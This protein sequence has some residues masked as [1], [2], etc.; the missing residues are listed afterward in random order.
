MEFKDF[1]GNWIVK[2]ILLAFALV[3]V[4]LLGVQIFLGIYTRHGD[5]I[6]VPDFVSLSLTE[7]EKAAERVGMRTEVVDSLY[8]RKMPRGAIVRQ[9]PAAGTM[10]KSGRRI[11]LTINAVA[12]KQIPM[13]NLVGYSLRSASAELAARGLTLGRQIYVR[14]IATNNVLKQIYNN[15]EIV[16][17]TMIPNDA[18]I[19][20]VLGLNPDDK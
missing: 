1:I 10:V 2:N 5:E 14:D 8:V 20:L 4:L 3:F 7:A 12:P 17:G 15:V 13:P 19:D 11:Q 16:P 6:S 18:V 9:E